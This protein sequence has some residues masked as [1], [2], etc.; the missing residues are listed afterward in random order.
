MNRLLSIF[1]IRLPQNHTRN[2]IVNM[3]SKPYLFSSK[4]V[5][6]ACQPLVHRKILLDL[7]PPITS[8]DPLVYNLTSYARSRYLILTRHSEFR[9]SLPFNHA[10]WSLPDIASFPPLPSDPNQ[11]WHFSPLFFLGSQL[12]PEG[13]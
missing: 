13:S 6:N 3:L 2:F 12:P 9:K 7:P 11:T 4:P 8:A 10:I 1:S 5:R